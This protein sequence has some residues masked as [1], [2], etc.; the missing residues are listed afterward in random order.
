[1]FFFYCKYGRII[2]TVHT[3]FHFSIHAL[4][5]N[6]GKQISDLNNPV[7]DAI[8]PNKLYVR[9]Y[10][11]SSAHVPSPT[12]GTIYH[13][14]IDGESYAT[15]LAVDLNR[16]IFA[17]ARNSGTWSDW[18]GYTKNADLQNNLK[19]AIGSGTNCT[20]KFNNNPH[21]KCL[22]E[23]VGT[24]NG[25]YL[26]LVLNVTFSAN[27]F[28]KEIIILKKDGSTN[29]NAVIENGAIKITGLNRYGVFE[30]RVPKGFNI[31]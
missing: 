25:E 6:L 9:R 16:D 24:N 8:V 13:M 31:Q 5:N 20:I 22:L 28:V 27:A 30:A 23:F 17:R 15:Q 2:F 1:M 18:E 29:V 12:H 14:Y 4:N 19:I 3:H 11:A 7:S 21:D 10:S 26:Y